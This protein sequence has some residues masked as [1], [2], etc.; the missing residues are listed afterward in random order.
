MSCPVKNEEAEWCE[1]YSMQNY[2]TSVLKSQLLACHKWLSKQSSMVTYS[3]VC[4]DHANPRWRLQIRFPLNVLSIMFPNPV[5]KTGLRTA[6]Y[7]IETSAPTVSSSRT[8]NLR[9]IRCRRG[10]LYSKS[11]KSWAKR[12]YGVLIWMNYGWIMNACVI[13]K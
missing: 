5:A 11:Y 3:D 10:Y 13:F 1:K 9:A 12:E 2:M 6:S 8:Y 4:A 7:S